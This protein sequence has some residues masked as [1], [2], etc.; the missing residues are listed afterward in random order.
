MF[1]VQKANH[2]DSNELESGSVHNITNVFSKFHIQL[3][4]PI[5]PVILFNIA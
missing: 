4:F 1:D 3:F 2:F 5:V